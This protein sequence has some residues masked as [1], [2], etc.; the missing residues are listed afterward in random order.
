MAMFYS[1]EDVLKVMSD[2]DSNSDCYDDSVTSESDDEYAVENN[3]IL[4][5]E[6]LSASSSE[7]SMSE[8]EEFV[9]EL[10]GANVSSPRGGRGSETQDSHAPSQSRRGRGQSSHGRGSGQSS[11]GRGQSTGRGRGRRGRTGRRQSKQNDVDYKRKEVNL[12]KN[13]KI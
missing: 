1:V 13:G 10:E 2:E 12:G 6:L 9:P 11:R 8:C 4:F 3:D 5:E 7:E